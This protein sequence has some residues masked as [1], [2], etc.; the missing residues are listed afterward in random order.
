MPYVLNRVKTYVQSVLKHFIRNHQLACIV[1]LENLGMLVYRQNVVLG[2][3]L[4]CC[5]S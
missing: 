3:V 2:V 4:R 1:V 5:M